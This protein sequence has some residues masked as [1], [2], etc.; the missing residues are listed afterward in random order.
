MFVLFNLLIKSLSIKHAV[1]YMIT[2]HIPNLL[3]KKLLFFTVYKNE[4]K[5]RKF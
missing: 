3:L 4:W 1:K 5:E 2:A